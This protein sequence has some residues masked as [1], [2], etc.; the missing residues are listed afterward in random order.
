VHAYNFSFGGQQDEPPELDETPPELEEPVPELD[1]CA[2]ELDELLPEPELDAPT[3]ELDVPP[4]PD[5]P[6]ELDEVIGSAEPSR[7]PMAT[8]PL[9]PAVVDKTTPTA[10]SADVESETKVRVMAGSSLDT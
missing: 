3:P 1:E 8:K 2:P 10:A 6:P 5:P 4:E 9:Q 7:S